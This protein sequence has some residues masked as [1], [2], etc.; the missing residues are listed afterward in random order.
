MIKH[1]PKASEWNK[2]RNIITKSVKEENICSILT[3]EH[4]DSTNFETIANIINKATKELVNI[5]FS[6]Q[7][8]PEDY[9]MQNNIYIK[10]YNLIDSIIN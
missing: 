4:K 3:K 7:Q 6:K 9:L 1:C 10:Y 2:K 8:K 5:Y